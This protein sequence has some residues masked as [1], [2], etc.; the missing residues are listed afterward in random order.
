MHYLVTGGAGFIGS[1][2]IEALLAGGHR[3]SVIDDLSTGKRAQAPEAVRLVV[4]DVAAPGA[5]DALV[6]DIDGAFHLAAI[7][8][9]EKSRTDWLRTHQVNLGGTVALFDA[10]ARTGRHTPV[11]FASSAA[12]YGDQPQLPI[13]ET[14]PCRPLSAYGAD[15]FAGELQARIAADIHGIPNAG[16]RFFNVYGPRQDPASP[17]SGV[18]SIFAARMKAAQPITIYGDGKQSRDFVYVGDV[19]QGMVAAM[20]ALA[21]GRVHHGVYNI[22]SNRQTTLLELVDTLRELTGARPDITHAPAREGEIR[23]S[24]GDATAARDAFGF[25]AP[26]ALPGGLTRTLE[27]L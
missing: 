9:V 21:A 27:A 3:I 6:G 2:L 25:I 24:L 18:I 11:V 1:H 13:V 23:H 22:A 17:Y 14:M 19:A 5:F 10:I 20:Q 8:S 26:T 12:V 7:A 15:K 4:G 16:L